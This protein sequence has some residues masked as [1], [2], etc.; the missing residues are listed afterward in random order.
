MKPDRR[1]HEYYI[2]F[3]NNASNDIALYQKE[4]ENYKLAKDKQ[5]ELINNYKD[6]YE[7]LFK[8]YIEDE[9]VAIK[10]AKL[11]INT[12]TDPNRRFLLSLI[13]KYGYILDKIIEYNNM[14][15]LTDTRKNLK[16]K[17]YE[18]I[19]SRFYCR[20]H[21]F[22]LQGFGYV[23]TQGIGTLCIS[24]WRVK[25]STKPMVDFKATNENKRR[26]LAEGKKLYN[27]V[28][29][30]WYKERGIPY[31]GVEY[32]VYTKTSNVYVIDIIKSKLFRHSNHIFRRTEYINNKFKGLGFKGMAEICDTLDDISTF[33]VD[34][35]YK[36][37]ILLYKDPTQY[38][39]FI[40]NDDEDIHKYGAHNS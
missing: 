3:I 25:D 24:R 17:E 8:I 20:V 9:H 35:K 15:K 2:S 33:P 28:E 14:I 13:L 11:I 22:V 21:K 34:L 31:D 27:K 10:R 38:I 39:K 36:L 5:F 18:A 16:F 19:V 6:N 7:T 23:Y 12:E 29:A 30:D 4:V 40:R 1:I 37:N 32:I 26:L